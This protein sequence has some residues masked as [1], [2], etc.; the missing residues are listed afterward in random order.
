MNNALLIR[1]LDILKIEV[2]FSDIDNINNVL[3]VS[4]VST[5][6]TLK[7][8]ELSSKL[9]IHLIGF[10][11]R[12]GDDINN[13]KACEISGYDY[14]GSLML[15]CK[16]DDRYNP[17]PFNEE[18]LDR[19][20]VYLTTGKLIAKNRGDLFSAFCDRYDVKPVLP[21][22]SID[23]EITV[24]DEVPCVLI[25]KYDLNKLSDRELMKLGERLF[26]FSTVLINEFKQIDDISLSKDGKYYMK[27]FMYREGKDADGCYY[28]FVQIND[29]GELLIRNPEE[30]IKALNEKSGN[31]EYGDDA[32]EEVYDNEE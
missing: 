7:T 24:K 8:Q 26:D 11:D 23:P 32:I 19:V 5:I 20:Y 9:G 10:V 6:H 2:D 28:V 1:N 31:H 4:G 17:L 30:I 15:L 21:N 13:D 3:N 22:F 29:G 18:E 12:N 16:T 27:P 14:I 25:A